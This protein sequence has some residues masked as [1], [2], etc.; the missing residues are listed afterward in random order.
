LAASSILQ[1]G[2]L[3]GRAAQGNSFPRLPFRGEEQD[4][5]IADHRQHK[6]VMDPDAVGDEALSRTWG[7][8]TPRFLD[9][10]LCAE[11]S[12]LW[13]LSVTITPNCRFCV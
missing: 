11:P 9:P 4:V 10:R 5:Q 3:I 2:T 6:R 1:P 13:H 12:I 8:E 7:I